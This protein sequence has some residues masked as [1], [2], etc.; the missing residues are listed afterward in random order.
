MVD[1]RDPCSKEALALVA[2]RP[3]LL[4]VVDGL[5]TTDMERQ[6]F[7][8]WDRHTEAPS[9]EERTRLVAVDLGIPI[10]D[11]RAVLACMGIMSPPEFYRQMVVGLF[12]DGK[13]VD[14]V[15]EVLRRSQDVILE[16]AIAA[17]GT[18]LA[19]RP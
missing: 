13:S 15:H 3:D 7:E 16:M 10:D 6:V 14:D 12:K 17:Y 1:I 8:S 19:R 18:E 5:R 4:H 11:L 2:V 9:H